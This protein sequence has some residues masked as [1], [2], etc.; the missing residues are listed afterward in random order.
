MGKDTLIH[1]RYNEEEQ[2][3]IELIKSLVDN[4][5]TQASTNAD[6]LADIPNIYKLINYGGV[7]LKGF[8]HDLNVYRAVKID[9][10]GDVDKLSAEIQTEAN[11]KNLNV[12]AELFMS[13]AVVLIH[14]M[15]I[16]AM[17]QGW[18]LNSATV[19]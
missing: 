8:L 12:H 14:Y 17:H 6:V 2:P 7:D 10:N 19:I 9:E 13:L 5:N 1:F 16:W 18:H 11:E 3:L 15:K 4:Y